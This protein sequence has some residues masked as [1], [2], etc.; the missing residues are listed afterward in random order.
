[1]RTLLLAFLLAFAAAPALAAEGLWLTWDECVLDPAAPHNRN[2]PCLGNVNGQDLYCAF[3]M[4]FPVDSVL[5]VDIVVDVQHGSP[6][7][8]SWWQ[9][10][11]DSCRAGQLR[12]S[13]D[14]S[15]SSFCTDFW[16]GNGV[17]GLQGYYQGE[18]R[19][20]ANQAR[21]KIAGAV[22]P[23]FG[24]RQLTAADVYYAAKLTITNAHTVDPGGCPGCIN[25]ACLVLNSIAIRRQPGA[26][27]G[28]VFLQGPGPGNG[29]FATWQG[30]SGADC[31][32]VPVRSMTWGRV[33]SLY[34]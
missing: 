24:Y 13:F 5:G 17:G 10:A 28:D 9:F 15:T 26:P 14:F 32:A 31:T 7:L 6:V 19:G 23:G 8:P 33:K 12:V 27:G 25:P 3:Q 21:I 20:G 2:S 34:R 30:G 29:N 22:L 11:P 16:F 1:M 18:P 4:P